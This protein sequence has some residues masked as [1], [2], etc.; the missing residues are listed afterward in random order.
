M[1]YAVKT[2]Y[3]PGI[4]STW[5]ECSLQVKGYPGAKY[6]KFKTATEALLWL[7]AKPNAKGPS[8]ALT[9]KFTPGEVADWLCETASDEDFAEFF[10][11]Y[12]M[13]WKDPDR[14]EFSPLEAKDLKGFDV[15]ELVGHL[16]Q[17]LMEIL[18]SEEIDA[19]AWWKQKI[20]GPT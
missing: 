15:S 20:G 13:K 9:K 8:I 6:K 4:Y 12:Y 10:V 2:G 3:C 1:V 11:R 18:L 17:T 7:K 16:R 14:N 5:D 19:G